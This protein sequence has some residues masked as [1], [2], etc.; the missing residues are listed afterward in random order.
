M[1]MCV[2]DIEFTYLYDFSI[3]CWKCSDICY[4]IIGYEKKPA[5]LQL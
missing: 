4:F 5:E 1:Y 3:E 2:R